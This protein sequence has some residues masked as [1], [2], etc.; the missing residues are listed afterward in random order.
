MPVGSSG[1]LANG[2]L[3]VVRKHPS[4]TKPPR[5]LDGS[6]F[7]ADSLRKRGIRVSE[8][9]PT[10]GTESCPDILLRFGTPHPHDWDSTTE[11][12][13][14][15]ELHGYPSFAVWFQVAS[16][17]RSPHPPSTG[18]SSPAASAGVLQ[19]SPR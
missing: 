7:L 9:A 16:F 15:I 14:R 19:S 13:G 8:D 3:V 10:P 4:T 2:R 18:R 12:L 1:V 5:F 11:G 6:S 17:T